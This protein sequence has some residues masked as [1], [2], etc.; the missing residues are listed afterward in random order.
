MINPEQTRLGGQL[1][2]IREPRV[3]VGDMWRLIQWPLM[4]NDARSSVCG[5]MDPDWALTR[6]RQLN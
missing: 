4:I 5:D 6:P 3:N 2:F 1:R